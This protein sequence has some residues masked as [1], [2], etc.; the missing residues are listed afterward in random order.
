[1][2]DTGFRVRTETLT[3]QVIATAKPT[4]SSRHVEWRFVR[5]VHIHPLWNGRRQPY[6]HCAPA[7]MLEF[8]VALP[9]PSTLTAAFLLVL[10]V[11]YIRRHLGWTS[12]SRGRPLPP[13]PPG[14][15]IIG[16]VLDIPKFKMWLGFQELSGRYGT[17][18]QYR[19]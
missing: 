3:E 9:S 14:L 8:P 17:S 11:I 19:F 4:H 12:R 1:M 10:A 18:V 7:D 2:L 5:V 13:G 16:N 6:A 15:P